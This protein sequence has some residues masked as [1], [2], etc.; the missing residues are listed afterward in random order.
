MNFLGCDGTW[1]TTQDGSPYCNG[2][3]QTFTAQEMQ[4][5]VSPALTAA[6]RM[7]ITGALLG[8]FVFVWVCRT[9]R[10]AF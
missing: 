1:L 8:L 3:L 7:E 4:E 6:Q 10:N 5:A 9:V 2:Q